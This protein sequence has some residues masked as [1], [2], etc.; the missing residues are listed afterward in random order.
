MPTKQAWQRAGLTVA[1]LKQVLRDNGKSTTGG[2][3]ELL[4]RLVEAKIAI[5]ASGGG[6]GGVSARR[7][8]RAVWAAHA[9]AYPDLAGTFGN[10]VRGAPLVT[11]PP[12][13]CPGLPPSS[14]PLPHGRCLRDCSPHA[15][16]PPRSLPHLPPPLPS[17][18]LPSP[19]LP[20]AAAALAAAAPA[21]P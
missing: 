19:T 1:Q 18:R 3:D 2:Q 6:W 8:G 5:P 15:P 9:H 12:T 4:K 16:P 21:R 13:P 7:G 11:A 17:P 20:L 10:D 14:Q